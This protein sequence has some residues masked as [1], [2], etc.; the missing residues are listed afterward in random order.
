M[1]LGVDAW[2]LW[3]VLFIVFLLIEAF[4]L[5]LVTIW[6]AVGSL[7]ALAMDLLGFP[8]TVQI[9]VMLAVSLLTF[10][11]FMLVIKPRTSIGSRKPVPT[12]ADRIIGKEGLVTET[13]D[14]IQGSGLIMVAGQAWSAVSEDGQS[15]LIDSHVQVVALKGVKAV[16]KPLT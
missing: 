3:L 5:N 11:L 10:A 14:P 13:I 15:I 1:I 12:N 8:V 9:V 6:F 16:V 7:A 2:I 4:T